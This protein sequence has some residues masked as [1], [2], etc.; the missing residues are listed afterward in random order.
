MNL[1]PASTDPSKWSLFATVC[2]E[3]DEVLGMSSAL[4]NLANG[5]PPPTGAIAPPDLF[6]YDG[7]GARSFNTLSNTA[8]YFSL[9]GTT[10]LVRFNQYAGGDY[11]D[12][13]SWPF[14][15]ATPRVQ[16]AF[17][18]HGANPVPNVE[19]TMLD[20]IG[21]TRVISTARPSLAITRSGT[22]VIVTWPA[23]FLSY[24]LQNA[25]SLVPVVNWT[26]N[27]TTPALV[28]G[29]YSV[30]NPATGRQFYRLIK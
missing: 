23:T 7:S 19:L 14:G 18:T 28:N 22:N 10:D 25:T 17:A 26:T 16:D 5:A 21:Y 9:D 2:H 24:T 11:Q 29:Q 12:W 4:N 8:A 30:T 6:R 20:V 15:A 3:I 27:P 13:Y 1:S